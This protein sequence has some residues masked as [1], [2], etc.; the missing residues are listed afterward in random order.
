MT[1]CPNCGYRHSEEPYAE[2]LASI[3]LPNLQHNILLR[4]RQARG[5][6]V[7]N[8]HIVDFL[9]G[10]RPDGGPNTAK[11]CVESSITWIRKKIKPFGWE[12]RSERFVGYR[13]VRI[14]A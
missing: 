6:M 5:A 9:Y 7:S 2:E 13:L 11:Y 12:I 3:R 4:S 8:E 1:T 10:D 14:E